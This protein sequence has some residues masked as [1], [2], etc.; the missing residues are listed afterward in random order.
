[1]FTDIVLEALH[2]GPAP[3]KS[4]PTCIRVLCADVSFSFHSVRSSSNR[5]MISINSEV[6]T[7][8]QYRISPD[9]SLSRLDRIRRF[10]HCFSSPRDS[11]SSSVL[12]LNSSFSSM[13]GREAYGEF[14]FE[15]PMLM[16]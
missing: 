7:S 4:P 8:H 6:S 5:Q 16:S 12:D 15:R 3:V 1:V 14:F 2:V 11:S 13:T 9:A 10:A